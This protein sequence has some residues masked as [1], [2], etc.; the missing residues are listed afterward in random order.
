M[1][2]PALLKF[3][4]TP[5]PSSAL[6]V[7]EVDE[8]TG[9][10]NPNFVYDEGPQTDEQPTTA[11][12]PHAT[13]DEEEKELL[14]DMID[15]KFVE[16]PPIIEEDIFVERK[17]GK[18]RRATSPQPTKRKARKPLSEEDKQKRREALARGRETRARNLRKKKELEA[19]QQ[20]LDV[21]EQELN[22]E[23]KQLDLEMRN[24]KLNKKAK[25][26]KKVIIEDSS[27]SEEEVQ[28]VKRS[29]KKKP[30]EP[31]VEQPSR[32]SLGGITAEDI[33]RSQLNTLLAY[34]K[35]RKDRKQEKQRVK[36]IEQEQQKIKQ[37]MNE[38]NSQWGRHRGAGKYGNMLAQMG[39]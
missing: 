19:Q 12:T 16:K 31:Q 24:A 34:E 33:E 38:V 18:P 5:P 7:I 32:L 20:S 39:L 35:L 21:Q 2:L 36:Q 8:V 29:R 4:I 30:R 27:S 13:E 14:Q 22:L 37:T 15:M 6:P 17:V 9:E 25:K 23:D 11:A 28:Y 10:E 26:V 3:D 1:S